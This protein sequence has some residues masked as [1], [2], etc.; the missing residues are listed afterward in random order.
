MPTRDRINSVGTLQS[1]T[2]AGNAA[3]PLITANNDRAGVRVHNFDASRYLYVA[4]INQGDAAPGTITSA[5][6]IE[7]IPPQTSAFIA[8][9]PNVRLYGQFSSGGATTALVNA[10]ELL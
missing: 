2:V 3:A 4:L 6:A 10:Q 1:N 9:G 5:T 8:A 7:E